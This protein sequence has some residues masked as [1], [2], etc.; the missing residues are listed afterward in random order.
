SLALPEKMTAILAVDVGEGAVVALAEEGTV[1]HLESRTG[2]LEEQI[3][4]Q[5][6]QPGRTVKRIAVAGGRTAVA[7]WGGTVHVLDAEGKV[8]TAQRLEQDVADMA[9]LG[10]RLVVGLADGTVLGL[11]AK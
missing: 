2:K 8:A 6:K 7:Y 10:G 3:A 4:W 11:D 9:W 5:Y 1:V